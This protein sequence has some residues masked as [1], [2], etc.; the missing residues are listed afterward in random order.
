[1]KAGTSTVVPLELYW[2]VAPASSIP[3]T[4]FLGLDPLTRPDLTFLP[5]SVAVVYTAEHG[6]KRFRPSYVF[7]TFEDLPCKGLSHCTCHFRI[8]NSRV[9]SQRVLRIVT[10][11]CEPVTVAR[12]RQQRDANPVEGGQQAEGLSSRPPAHNP[13]R[14][15]IASWARRTSSTTV[16]VQE[17]DD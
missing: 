16:E 11:G 12:E 1:M 2:L 6:A 15:C 17:A 3:P 14:L 8:D 9:D 10:H 13:C 5:A 7:D 4:P